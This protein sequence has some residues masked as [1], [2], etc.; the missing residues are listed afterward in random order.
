MRAGEGLFGIAPE[1][2][3]VIL[4]IGL[5]VCFLL[6]VTGAVYVMRQWERAEQ[7]L[8]DFQNGKGD[9]QETRESKMVSQLRQILDAAAY[10]ENQAVKEKNEV[11]ELLSD[12]SHQLKTPLANIRMNM[13]ILENEELDGEKRKE[14]QR[15]TAAQAEKMQ[16]LMQSLL[17]ASRLENGMI[18]F[19]AENTDIKET[20]ARAVGAVY[21]QAEG[22]EIEICVE[23]FQDFSL[24]HNPKW[25]AEAL[26]NLLENAVKYSPEGSTIRI[27]ISRMDIYTGIQVSDQGIGIPAAEYNRIFQRFYRGKE[28]EQ[29]EGTGLGLYLAQLILQQ[30][31]GYITVASKVGKGS[32][33]TVFLLNQG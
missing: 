30:E 6:L 22:K 1:I 31:K 33:F 11:A 15:L 25:T 10:K 12:L 26:T 21:A 20:I 18:A 16:W 5:L 32:T 28:V 17:K 9:V 24:Y 7:L 29:E 4:G 19:R 2:W 8:E 23:E 13:E 27:G 3:N 14:F